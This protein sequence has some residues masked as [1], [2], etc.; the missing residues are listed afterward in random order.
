MNI[1]ILLVSSRPIQSLGLTRRQAQARQQQ[2]AVLRVAIRQGAG[3]DHSGDR[4]KLTD[5]RACFVESAHVGVA[6]GEK[7]V[8][9]W[10]A[11]VFLNGQ[12]QGRRGLV[13]PTL[14]KPG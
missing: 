5:N 8:G 2:L 3:H 9:D 14:E 4:A 11:G 1:W 13:K 10:S 7:T 12:K 6:G